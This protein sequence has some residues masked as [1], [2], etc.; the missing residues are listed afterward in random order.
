MTFKKNDFV[1]VDF[2]IYAND[3]LVQTTS[4]KLG[5][6]N[7]LKIN[8]YGPQTIVIGKNMILAALDNAIM[9]KDKGTLELSA[10][11]AY[12][13]KKKELLKTF[14]S[15]A[16][17]EQKL[18]PVV[19]MTYDFNGMYGA[20]RSII[21]NRVTVD[22]NNPLAGK[23]IRIEYSNAK[24]VSKIEDKMFFVLSNGL[25]IPVS[26]FAV[27][28][29]GKKVNLKV[30]TKMVAMKDKLAAAFSELISDFS[31]Y[32]FNVESLTSVKS[33]K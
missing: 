28:A 12:G 11:D 22:F 17:D 31:D 5:K 20:V 1:S 24:E 3:K 8:S 23:K 6:A 16:F 14:P 29:S 7:G 19:G 26:S 32:T 21:S 27:S 10:S 13:N 2:N 4:E 15:S 33:K 25:K 30:P 18:K 9:K